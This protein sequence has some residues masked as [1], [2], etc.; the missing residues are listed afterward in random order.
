MALSRPAPP[1]AC[2]R[3]ASSLTALIQA[4]GLMGGLPPTPGSSDGRGCRPLAPFGPRRTPGHLGSCTWRRG[5]SL[6]LSHTGQEPRAAE[7]PRPSRGTR[8][9]GVCFWAEQGVA[10]P[11]VPRILE[12]K[13]GEHRGA[14]LT[15]D[16]GPAWGRGSAWH[17]EEQVVGTVNGSQAPLASQ[18]LGLAW[19]GHEP[20][21]SRP[22]VLAWGSRAP[23]SSCGDR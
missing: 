6:S 7:M 10:T 17:L 15:G 20:L 9:S 18:C 3:L 19:S 13:P 11:Q 16:E 22:G 8:L 4:P 14:G 1:K 21:T 2:S 12:D 5:Q 23:S